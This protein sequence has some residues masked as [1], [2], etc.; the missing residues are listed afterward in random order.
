MRNA[1]ED[2]DL[3]MGTQS[4]GPCLVAQS[5]AQAQKVAATRLLHAVTA[6]GKAAALEGTE[7]AAC[8]AEVAVS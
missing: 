7:T 6:R 1:M 3:H 8:L 5:T 2:L 4:S